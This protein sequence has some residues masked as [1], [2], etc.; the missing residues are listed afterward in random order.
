[1]EIEEKLMN[2]KYDNFEQEKKLLTDKYNEVINKESAINTAKQRVENS[3]KEIDRKNATIAQYNQILSANI[4]E[5]E[6]EL[7]RIH[8]EQE[9]LNNER[10]N[11]RIRQEM[12]DNLRMKYIGDST[13][14]N[15][16]E[17]T[18]NQNIK[19][20]SNFNYGDYRNNI[21]RPQYEYRYNFPINNNMDQSNLYNSKNNYNENKDLNRVKNPDNIQNINNFEKQNNDYQNLGIIKEEN[22]IKNS[23]NNNNQ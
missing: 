21:F 6:N 12:I 15:I 5:V 14:N 2:E 11:L 18:L 7:N 19:V 23:S 13:Q 4:N 16:F 1:M 10:N 9:N 22:S 8:L 3:L 17:N 20:K